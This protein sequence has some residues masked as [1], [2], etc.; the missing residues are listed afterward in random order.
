MGAFTPR[1]EYSKGP[2]RVILSINLH[3]GTKPFDAVAREVYTVC[4]CI[5]KPRCT[6]VDFELASNTAQLVIH[7]E[8][9]GALLVLLYVVGDI[10][11]YLSAYNELVRRYGIPVDVC[12]ISFG[13][14]HYGGT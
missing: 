2:T 1:V 6:L 9:P 10:G 5:A 13:S 4:N 3:A 11:Q 14:Q 7:L 8:V 12:C